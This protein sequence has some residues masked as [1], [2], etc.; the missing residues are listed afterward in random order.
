[1]VVG[2]FYFGVGEHVPGDFVVGFKVL[3]FICD[4]D[5][6]WCCFDEFECSD[7]GGVFGEVEGFC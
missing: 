5:G 6:G 7:G 3:D 1:M 2:F 4:G